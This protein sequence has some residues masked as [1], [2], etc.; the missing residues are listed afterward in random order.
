[1]ASVGFE[2]QGS[3]ILEKNLGLGPFIFMDYLILMMCGKL[4]GNICGWPGSFD[5]RFGFRDFY[6]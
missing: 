5:T 2:L 1:M 6:F 4:K 3:G